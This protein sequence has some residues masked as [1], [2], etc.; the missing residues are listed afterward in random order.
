MM[1]INRPASVSFRPVLLLLVL[2]AGSVSALGEEGVLPAALSAA[3][4]PRPSASVAE[5]SGDAPIEPS[6]VLT[7]R[8]GAWDLVGEHYQDW[9]GVG[10]EVT[11]QSDGTIMVPFAGIIPAAGR[12]TG[13]IADEISAALRAAIGVRSPPAVA[14]AVAQRRPIY[15]SGDVTSPGAIDF[16][17][18]LTVR[19]AIALAGG[20]LRFPPGSDSSVLGR[21][22]QIREAILR[23][24]L[25]IARLEAELAGATDFDVPEEVGASTGNDSLIAVE[26]RLMQSRESALVAQ[27]A[28]VDELIDV[29]MGVKSGLEEQIALVEA[30]V[31]RAQEELTR[32]RDLLERGLVRESDVSGAES[33]L[34]NLRLRL[35]DMSTQYLTL[36]KD[37]SEARRS[38]DV[39]AQARE[40]EI[41]EELSEVRDNRRDREVEAAIFLPGFA[42][43]QAGD[44]PETFL[45]IEAGSDAQ[46]SVDPETPLRPGD[47][48][49]I[50]NGID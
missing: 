39:L 9:Q 11:V 35:V 33:S 23:A 46:V 3:S 30:E 1:P 13:A 45:L 47:T 22:A 17:D 34:S 41:L 20:P 10:G 38:R 40:I 27:T 24:D 12:T 44:A 43:G 50:D 18:G 21:Q 36:E 14:V 29:L 26:R 25:R 42:A 48:L 2:A 15:V 49:I 32:R 37:L 5:R 16:R 19:Q 7:L 28:S 31:G 8:V 4:E 6:D